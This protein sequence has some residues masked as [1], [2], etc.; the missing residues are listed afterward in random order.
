MIGGSLDAFL[1][2]RSAPITCGLGFYGYINGSLLLY[3]AIESAQMPPCMG[4]VGLLESLRKIACH[5]R[6][7]PAI[8]L[9]AEADAA[10]AQL[11]AQRA[12]TARAVR[13]RHAGL[14]RS[15]IPVAGRISQGRIEPG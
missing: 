9:L 8:E 5:E 12:R 4:P 7:R 13:H 14:I 10:V 15:P 6:D 1:T 2:I 11:P 3:V